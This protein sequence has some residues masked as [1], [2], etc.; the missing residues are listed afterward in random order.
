MK[1]HRLLKIFFFGQPSRAARK[2]GHPRLGWEYVIKKDLR[3]MGTSWEG[4]KREV[5]RCIILCSSTSAHSSA[6]A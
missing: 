5:L 1:D 2:A 4:V 3:E 6:S